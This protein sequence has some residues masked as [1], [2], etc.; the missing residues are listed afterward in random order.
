MEEGVR[1]VSDLPGVALESLGRMGDRRGRF[2]ARDVLRDGDVRYRSVA[3]AALVGMGD[4]GLD[5]LREESRSN[6][7]TVRRAAMVAIL[8]LAKPDDLTSLYEYIDAFA[9]DDPEIAQKIRA[10]AEEL[11]IQ[12]QDEMAVFDDGS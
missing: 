6:N 2:F 12:W 9:D 7:P 1:R 4:E 11:E 10:R 3:A 5:M 8:P